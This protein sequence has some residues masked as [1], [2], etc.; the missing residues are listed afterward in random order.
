[1]SD[2][3]AKRCHSSGYGEHWQRQAGAFWRDD[4][5]MIERLSASQPPVSKPGYSVMPP[6][7]NSVVPTM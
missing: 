5:G 3:G 7:M 4:A 1:M 2:R 6:S